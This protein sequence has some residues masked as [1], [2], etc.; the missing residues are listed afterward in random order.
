MGRGFDS[1]FRAI[2]I[3]QLVRTIE[4]SQVRILQSI[5]VRFDG[6]LS[7]EHITLKKMY[8]KKTD[9]SLSVQLG[10]Q[11]PKRTLARNQQELKYRG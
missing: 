2:G 3:V 6:W 1:R 4:R 10:L 5:L 8:H 11:N 9:L 7:L